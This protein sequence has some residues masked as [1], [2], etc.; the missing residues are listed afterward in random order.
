MS[1]EYL[2]RCGNNSFFLVCFRAVFMPGKSLGS[3]LLFR[4]K[5]Y[6]YFRLNYLGE[7]QENKAADRMLS[8]LE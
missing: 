8:M 2:F 7:K 3:L 4:K 6:D 1:G 5:W